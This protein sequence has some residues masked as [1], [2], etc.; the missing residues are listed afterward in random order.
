MLQIKELGVEYITDEMGEK[1]AV[2]L[3][4][5]TFRRLLEDF[6][7]LAAVAERRNEETVSHDKLLA[8]LEHDGIL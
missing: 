8:E 3:P 5:R 1:K 6:E 2:I 4:I 7:D